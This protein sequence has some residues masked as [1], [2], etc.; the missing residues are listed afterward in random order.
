MTLEEPQFIV[1]DVR[2]NML[3]RKKVQKNFLTSAPDTFVCHEIL[4][5]LLELNSAHLFLILL[6]YCFSLCYDSV[7]QV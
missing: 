4:V 5:I 2:V 7:S 1:C 3:S 6:L